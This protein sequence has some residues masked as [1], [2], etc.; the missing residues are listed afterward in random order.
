MKNKRIIQFINLLIFIICLTFNTS[1]FA[2]STSI[3]TTTEVLNIRSGPG[4][5]YSRIDKVQKNVSVIII[6]EDAAGYGCSDKWYHIEYNNIKGYVCGTYVKKSNVEVSSD[7][8]ASYKDS[9]ALLKTIYP[10][11]TFTALYT[12]LDW[13]EAV[14]NQSTIGKSL[15]DGNDTNLRSKDPSVYDAATGKFK[16]IEPGWYAANERT[17]AY[18]LDPRN[19]LDQKYIFMFENLSFDEKIHTTNA[20]ESVLKNSYMPKLYSEYSQTIVKYS[21]EYKASSIYVAS[22]ILQET[23]SKGSVST[24]GN[25]FVYSYDSSTGL[26]N[27]KTYSGLYNFFNIGAY[28]Y[29]SPAIKGL[30]WANGGEDGT[31][32]SYNRPWT[33]PEKALKGGID[34]LSASY[35]SK[36]QNTGYFQKFN[37]SPFS[38]YG[39]YTHQY[40]T[41]IRAAYYE[42]SSTYNSYNKLD[43]L[44]ESF[45]FLIPVYNNMPGEIELP[46]K[47]DDEPEKEEEYED[48]P[49]KTIMS[50]LGVTY[51]TKTMYGLKIG[52][53]T[54]TLAE[55][56]KSVSSKVNVVVTNSKGEVKDG[57]IGT[58]DKIKIST[59][60][61]SSSYNI[62]IYGDST[63]DGNISIADL[64]RTQKIILKEVSVSE[65]FM[66]GTDNNKDGNVTILDLLRVQKHILGEIT[67]K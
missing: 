5:N 60:S 55:S 31:L 51:D 34:Y 32:T 17:V 35:I 10:N 28:G 54:T 43:L 2:S 53:T 1:V 9:I 25:S 15:I 57:K 14:K 33:S 49:I 62:I 56:I 18:Y 46:D 11:A 30:I 52:T 66:K 7:F 29:R 37:V 63:G 45:D 26:G 20:V 65:E 22:R 36:G 21:S 67:I 24:T 58:G 23:G 50:T 64:L 48:I 39:I 38:D 61:E 44:D 41:N 6:K 59:K 42:A 19:F 4:T 27:D 3:G 40:M 47:E 8:P 16:A 12:D 13:N